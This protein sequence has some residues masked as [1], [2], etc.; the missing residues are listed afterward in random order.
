MPT[1]DGTFF[2][3]WTTCTVY[4]GL[5]A[6]G[7]ALVGLVRAR[8]EGSARPFPALLLVSMLIACGPFLRVGGEMVTLAGM[9]IPLPGLTLA[10]LFPPFIVTALHSYRYTAVVMLALAV[11]A[12][13]AVQRPWWAG[14]IVI[15]MLLLSPVPWPAAVTPVPKSPVLLELR[16]MPPGAVLTAPMERENLGDLGRLLIAQTVHGK[17]VHDGGIHRRAGDEAVALFLENPV[18]D[19][20]SLYGAPEWPGPVESA[21]GFTHLY[22]E[23][24]RYL[25]MDASSEDGL[26]W[27]TELLGEP[28]EADDLWVLWVLGD[29]GSR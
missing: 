14:L 22:G 8:G 17:P 12:G 23:G 16:E 3:Y 2:E 15:E 1:P 25:L 5:V 18:V 4:L 29:V 24:Y 19:S 10:D 28:D 27:A 20:L 26:I 13:R 11:L 9:P 6:V 7:L 21:W